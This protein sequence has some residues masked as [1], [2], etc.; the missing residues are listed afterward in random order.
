MKTNGQGSK[1]P[2][3]NSVGDLRSPE[4]FGG[5]PPD[6]IALAES[7]DHKDFIPEPSLLKIFDNII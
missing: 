6:D 4:E 5:K 7:S 3:T 2:T 1:N